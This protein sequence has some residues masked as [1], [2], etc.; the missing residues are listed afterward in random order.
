MTR[1]PKLEDL[2]AWLAAQDPTTT[3]VTQER[4]DCLMTRFYRAFFQSDAI[5]SAPNPSAYRE[6][7]G[8]S[9]TGN[10]AMDA[11]GAMIDDVVFLK[12]WTY[13]GALDRIREHRERRRKAEEFP[14]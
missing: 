11:D 2:E 7:D 8:D 5:I 1:A 9:I 14:R 6:R 4:T 12:P 13:G 3:Y 10:R